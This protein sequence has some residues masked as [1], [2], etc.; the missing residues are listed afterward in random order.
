MPSSERT[1]GRES[2]LAAIGAFLDEPRASL[3]TFLIEGDVGIGKSTLWREAA[4]AA[5][6]R[7]YRVLA[8]RP[9]ETEMGIGF[10]GLIDLLG[11]VANEATHELPEPQRK[12][13][14][15]ALMRGSAEAPV[16]PG[17]VAVAVTGILRMLARRGPLAIAI[18]DSQWL[19]APT[20]RALGFALRRLDAEPIVVIVAR[21]MGLAHNGLVDLPGVVRL[22]VVP[23]SLGAT[24]QLVHSKRRL[25]CGQRA[26]ASRQAIRLRG[27][28]PQGFPRGGSGRL[29]RRR[30]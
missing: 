15:A 6:D 3:A 20:R 29:G 17:A 25:V 5:W 22:R 24:Y 9:D 28:S 2:E 26:P 10:A 23:L 1:V 12:A 8:C 7:S 14:D 13:L 19:D 4:R 27:R 21:R 16:E 30:P 11:D 18:D